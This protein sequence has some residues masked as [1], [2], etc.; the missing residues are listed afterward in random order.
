M[1]VDD[2]GR[3]E[4]L[5]RHRGRRCLCRVARRRPPR[6][7]ARWIGASIDPLPVEQHRG[8]PA[9]RYRGRRRG[10]L[11]A[12]ARRAFR[13]AVRPRSD[14][15]QASV[16][17]P[18]TI[19]SPESPSGSVRDGILYT[20]TQA[21]GIYALRVADGS[22]VWLAP[23]P[24]VF[25]PSTLVGDTLYLTS[26]MPPQIAAFRASDGSSLW[27]LPTSEI[28]KGHPVVSGGMLFATDASGEIRAYAERVSV[29]RDPTPTTRLLASPSA[30]IDPPESVRDRRTL[31]RD[32]A[33]ARSPARSGHR[34]E[35]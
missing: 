12:T 31:R 9:D 10:E 27:A 34:A 4:Q 29:D 8:R 22:Q 28:P 24:R 20:P 17:V 35:R 11:A 15:R 33:R 3:S 5:A 14:Q 1:V 26:E 6:R 30:P 2:K 19:G 23:G 32:Q 16:A 7:G 13:P 21:D 25:F 18:R